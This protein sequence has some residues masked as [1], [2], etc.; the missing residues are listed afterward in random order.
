MSL[1][2]ASP[3]QQFFDRDGSP[4][5]NGFV[6]VGT[7]NL[8]PETNPLTVYFDDALT[9]PAAQPLRTSNGYIVRNGS[10]ARLYTSQEDFS[11]TVR[12]KNSALVFTVADATSVSDLRTDLALSTGATLVGYGAGTVADALNDINNDLSSLLDADILV[13][14]VADLSG[15]TYADAPAGKTVYAKAENLLFE[16]LASGST[17][18]PYDFTDT[19]G[20]KLTFVDG[21]RQNFSIGVKETAVNEQEAINM[22]A[23]I[24]DMV[25]YAA[26]AGTTGGSGYSTY[27]VRNAYSTD[28]EGSL[29]W[30]VAQATAAGG[31]IILFQPRGFFNIN[32]T[33]QIEVPDN[34]TIDAPGRNA[35]IW[36]PYDVTRF[37]VVG[38]NVIIRRLSFGATANPATA[39]ARDA[40]WIEP[41]LSDK[42]WVDQC[43]FTWAGDGCIDIATL[44]ELVA[45][46]RITISKCQF[47]THDKASLIGSLACY[48]LAG[49]P[50]WCPTA[51]DDQTIRLFVTM[52]G[53]YF[54]CVGQRQ[55]KVVAQT[56]VDSVN[57]VVR[58]AP[59]E[60][61]DGTT[62]ACYGIFSAQG[63]CVR[64]RGDLF[65]AAT[66][67]G[68]AGVDASTNTYVPPSSGVS[69][70]EGQ[71]ASEVVGSVAANSI[72]M[73]DRET[74]Y[75]PTPPYT[76]TPASITDTPAGR[77]AFLEQTQAAA[78]ASADNV[79]EGTFRW[80]GSST[81]HPNTITQIS[82]TNGDGRWLRVD[83]WNSIPDYPEVITEDQP[84]IYPLGSNLIVASAEITV[85]SNG[86]YFSVDT[87]GAAATDDL[88][89]INGGVDGRMII[90]RSYLTAQAVT[91]KDNVG[92]IRMAGG[93]FT[94]TS[95]TN[96]ITLMF[97]ASLG[98]SGI[99]YEISRA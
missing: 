11:L 51:L 69:T 75:I 13:N 6:Y 28:T 54:H 83:R 84:V 9:I 56:F 35:Y 25:G 40:L 98:V 17:N 48:Q 70:I 66:G 19:G 32:L 33:E 26:S 67:S 37:K 52:T 57:N 45:D 74:S 87:E 53:N 15:L 36:A 86:V 8:N 42:V 92:N 78:G 88:E 94:F 99:W 73:T 64:S 7:A 55:P 39:T 46:C 77:R 47:S 31:G 62:G 21:V 80:D 24:S 82:E 85:P 14:G 5:D 81:L 23:D 71:G 22:A 3:F 97:D 58:M 1:Q 72:T 27:W 18:A 59:F 20:V 10:P 16:V 68:Y 38:S 61:D 43:S 63:G 50:A 96:R 95:T 41:S 34:V 2:I 60:R 49:R 89:T 90:L 93:D 79:S 91:I 44:V 4:L 65:L 30:A 29:R 12:D 76:I